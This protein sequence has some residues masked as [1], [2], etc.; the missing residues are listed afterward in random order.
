MHG[1]SW[2]G[3]ERGLEARAAEGP[4]GC[5]RAGERGLPFVQPEMRERASPGPMP[6]FVAL[7]S[8]LTEM[9]GDTL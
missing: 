3:Q 5:G 7:F 4:L 6:D 8:A 2:P 1:P 9:D